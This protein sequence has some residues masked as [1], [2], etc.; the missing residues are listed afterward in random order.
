MGGATESA[1]GG[2][3][4]GVSCTSMERTLARSSAS[5]CSIL[6][7]QAYTPHPLPSV[8]VKSGLKIE[9]AVDYLMY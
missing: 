7:L 3:G 2:A 1:G 6:Y 5:S 8:S 4:G 9:S